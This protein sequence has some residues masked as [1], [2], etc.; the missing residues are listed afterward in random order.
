MDDTHCQRAWPE[1]ISN[2]GAR[3]LSLRVGIALLQPARAPLTRF[4]A[5]LNFPP[6]WA[7]A[8]R[9]PFPSGAVRSP[10]GGSSHPA[11]IPS[12]PWAKR[13]FSAPPLPHSHMPGKP[14]RKRRFRVK[15]EVLPKARVSSKVGRMG[16]LSRVGT[17]AL[18]TLL[19]RFLLPF[20]QGQRGAWWVPARAPRLGQSE[21]CFLEQEAE[22]RKPSVKEKPQEPRKHTP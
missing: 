3:P 12:P 1:E 18:M 10:P 5:G 8:G 16:T 6:L 14:G 13:C 2:P 9:P 19:T 17:P 20:R 22:I 15:A 21:P 4:V 11:A 7:Q